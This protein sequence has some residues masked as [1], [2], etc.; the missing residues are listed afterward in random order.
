MNWEQPILAPFDDLSNNV[1]VDVGPL[2]E[3]HKYSSIHEKTA[4]L[5]HMNEY[6]KISYSDLTNDEFIR[7]F[8][9]DETMDV[10]PSKEPQLNEYRRISYLDQKEVGKEP[11]D[12]THWSLR[13]NIRYLDQDQTEVHDGPT[14]E[15]HRSKYSSTDETA[16][17]LGHLNFDHEA[18]NSV[19]SEEI[20]IEDQNDMHADRLSK[21]ISFFM[22][23]YFMD[24]HSRDTTINTVNASKEKE[25][26][27]PNNR[28]SNK[29]TLYDNVEEI[30]DMIYEGI[31]F[32]FNH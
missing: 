12:S 23:N 28:A 1:V 3:S 5:G 14:K 18:S 25:S 32:E 11:H 29:G 13:G 2:K 19:H 6:H 16:E 15:S 4:E 31:L 20:F 26:I 8:I 17:E 7:S 24:K 10:S 21:D 22:D 9:E 27:L 30:P